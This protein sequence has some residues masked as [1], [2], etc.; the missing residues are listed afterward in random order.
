MKVFILSLPLLLGSSRA[1]QSNEVG[2]FRRLFERHRRRLQPPPP[3]GG[4]GD[5]AAEPTYELCEDEDL[6]CTAQLLNDVGFTTASGTDPS[7]DAFLDVGE[8]I[9]GPFEAGFGE[10]QSDILIELGCTDDNVESAYVDGGIDTKT[11]LSMINYGC[12]LSLPY[13]DS[14]G[15]YRDLL[16]MCGGHTVEYHF[17]ER[18]SC[19]Y[20]ASGAH[21]TQVGIGLDGKRLYGKWENADASELPLLDACGGHFGTTPDSGGESI[22]HYHV[23][24]NAPFTFGCYGPNIDET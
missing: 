20:E 19:L 1:A 5:A 24:E 2:V 12:D 6:P 21:S 9:Y 16:D 14:G 18:L 23:Q 4:D 7:T 3:Q 15:V 13:T 8:N 10:S 22:Y 17:H 11:A